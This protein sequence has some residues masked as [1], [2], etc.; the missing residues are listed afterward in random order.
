MFEVCDASDEHPKHHA[1][2][3]TRSARLFT[4]I[5]IPAFIALGA[6]VFLPH[7]PENR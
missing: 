4:E 6:T 1:S 2:K 3:V 7:R 5:H